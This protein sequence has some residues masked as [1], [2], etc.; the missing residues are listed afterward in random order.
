MENLPEEIVFSA[1]AQASDAA[2]F[3]EYAR[4]MSA[5]RNRKSGGVVW[6]RH[7]PNAKLGCRCAKCG[8]SR[9]VVPAGAQFAGRRTR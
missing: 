1:L 3:S 7:Q 2:I 5:R 4:R 9:Q 8:Q 6:I